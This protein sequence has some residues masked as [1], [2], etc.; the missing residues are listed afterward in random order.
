MQQQHE[1]SFAM[2]LSIV[3]PS[4]FDRIPLVE[5]QAQDVST[6][7]IKAIGKILQD[8]KVNKHYS[9][10]LLHRHYG[11]PEDHVMVH[12]KSPGSTDECEAMHADIL[13]EDS[14]GLAVPFAYFLNDERKFQPFEYQLRTVLSP[15]SLTPSPELID[16][17]RDALLVRKLENTLCLTLNERIPTDMVGYETLRPD[18]EG[19]VTYLFYDWEVSADE[20]ADSTITSWVFDDV[21]GSEEGI[22]IRAVKRCRR[23]EGEKHMVVA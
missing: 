6:D 7:D 23:L 1:V 3:I 10:G 9:I 11:L 15:P 21:P 18:G 19:T 22:R 2:D 17:L 16:G 12:S 5:D 14:L 4:V 13:K 8:H 20:L